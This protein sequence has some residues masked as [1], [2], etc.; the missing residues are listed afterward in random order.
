M[1][2]ARI[3]TVAALALSCAACGT[4]SYIV[5]DE[6][7]YPISMS[8]GVRD[9]QGRLVPPDRLQ[10]LG[11]LKD[12]YTTCSMLWTLIPLKGRTRDISELVNEEVS[13]REGEAVVNLR[14]EASAIVTSALTLI[15][16]LPDCNDVRIRGDIVERIPVPDA[17]TVSAPAAEAP[18]VPAAVTEG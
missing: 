1:S 14:V 10:K 6:A 11:T 9:E 3:L 18:V 16:I 15:G 4:R 12:D 8:S 2:P 5:A 13:K 17:N 7:R